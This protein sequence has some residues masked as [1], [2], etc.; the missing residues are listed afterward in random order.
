MYLSTG[1]A[2]AKLKG[3]IASVPVWPGYSH[4][5]ATQFLSNVQWSDEGVSYWCV[6]GNSRYSW[7][8]V[9]MPHL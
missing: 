5:M 3:A 1:Q 2:L 7:Q 9:V 6:Y 8:T 4:Y